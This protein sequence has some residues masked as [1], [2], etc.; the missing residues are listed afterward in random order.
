MRMQ[1]TLSKAIAAAAL[2]AAN[3]FTPAGAFPIAPYPSKTVHELFNS[4]TRHYVL[5]SDPVEIA[6]VLRGDVGP[7]WVA[8]GYTFQARNEALA[9]P[10]ICRFHAPAPTSSHFFT[11]NAG[12]CAF[13]RNNN[14]GWD[15]EKMDFSIE[16]P[17]AG[18]CPAPL[19]PIYRV[20]NN[21]ARFS[22][23]NHRFVHDAT[24]RDEMLAAGWVDEGVAFCATGAVRGERKGFLIATQQVRP[25]TECEDEA[26]NL[27]PCVATN[28]MPRFT[29]RITSWL[30]PSFVN[31]DPFYS[32]RFTFLTGFDGNVFTAQPA[33]DA[34]AVASHSFAQT[35]LIADRVFGIHLSHAD[36]TVGTLASINPLYQFRTTAPQPGGAEERQFPWLYP[37][38]NEIVVSFNLDIRTIRRLNPASHAY[39]H[40]TLQF[41]DTKSGQHLYVTL[42]AYGTGTDG[43]PPNDL[44][45]MDS[46]TGRVIVGTAIGPNPL[47]G[48]RLAGEFLACEA[49]ANQGLCGKTGQGRFAFRI[50]RADFAKVLGLARALNPRLSEVPADYLLANFHFNNEIYREAELG[51]TLANYELKV[52]GY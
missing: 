14:T 1:S 46:G 40:P 20:Y 30:P 33:A 6:G 21:R 50:T 45:G 19:V 26:I 11:G 3:V 47:F 37:L 39:G 36:R 5:L 32:E 48:K 52:F 43:K 15:F 7:G 17:Q 4:F 42:G 51:L 49:D 16:V 28:Q 10:N 34:G 23:A 44:I 35:L 38:E 27:G 8:T 2:V 24:T 12:E 25:S 31:K 29:N 18:D 22:D 13:L 9:P 41:M